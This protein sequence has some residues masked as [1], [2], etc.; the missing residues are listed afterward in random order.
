MKK[1]N[2]RPEFIVQMDSFERELLAEI[3]F[4]QLEDE[5]KASGLDPYSFVKR[6]I[7]AEAY[8]DCLAAVSF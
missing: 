2:M 8:R 1:R 4:R 6:E 3:R 5:Y 7:S